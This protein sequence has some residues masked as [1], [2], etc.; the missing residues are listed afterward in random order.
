MSG[1]RT[2]RPYQEACHRQVRDHFRAGT[3]RVLVVLPTG[4]GKTDVAIRMVAEAAARGKRCLFFADRR[5]LVYQ[6]AARLR[7]AGLPAGVVMDGERVDVYAPVQVVSRDTFLSRYPTGRSDPPPADLVVVDEAHRAP[8]AGFSSILDAQYPDAYVVGL[9]ATP[10]RA[11]GRG[12]G[13]TFGAMVCPVRPSELLAQGY[14]VPCVAYAPNVPDLAGVAVDPKTRDYVKSQ[15]AERMT[16]E[17]V[18]GGAVKWWRQFAKDRPTI[19][20]ASSVP[21]S[22][23][24]RDQ[25]RAAGITAEHVDG[26]TPTAERDR[27][28]ADFV[29][30]RVSVLTNYDVLTEGVDLPNCEVIQTFRPSKLVRV[31]LQQWGRAMRPAPGK[32]H[33]TLIDHAGVCLYH[34]LPGTDIDWS[35]DPAA[36][37][38]SPCDPAAPGDARKPPPQVCKKC[39]TV[40][41]A[42]PA[43]PACGYC[44]TPAKKPK[45]GGNSQCDLVR[46]EAGS[47]ESDDGRQRERK[48]LW[49]Q[50]LG[51]AVREGRTVGWA[52]GVFKYRFGVWPEAA[53]VS[54][55]PE[56]GG[57]AKLAS[58][59]FPNWGRK[60]EASA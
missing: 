42:A 58:D 48:H 20:F 26:D 6:A 39:S 60:K 40:Y 34:G 27:V 29:A 54:P 50:L 24:L 31:V 32:T 38:V 44:P 11:D 10:T 56:P 49:G 23:S 9:T 55:L 33:W 52:A 47:P 43:C 45:A 53:G 41:P 59:V 13:A 19:A 46:V 37:S 51:R 18:V 14:L 1:L 35:L 8:S 5:L 25:Y 36:A 57:H 3:R 16:R 28:L 7:E 12:L 2:P 30:G 21:H 4:A 15:L 17:N 22:V